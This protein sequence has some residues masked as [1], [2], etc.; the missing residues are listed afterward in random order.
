[1]TTYK[2][3]LTDEGHEAA[4]AAVAAAENIVPAAHMSRRTNRIPRPRDP[5]TGQKHSPDSRQSI[6]QSRISS[7]A[8][9]QG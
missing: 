3:T 8:V 1:V 4:A 6:N 7:K 5:Q 2:E 9:V